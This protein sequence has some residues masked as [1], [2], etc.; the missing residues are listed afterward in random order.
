M[1]T[2]Q[3]NRDCLSKRFVRYQCI[4]KSLPQFLIQYDA[5]ANVKLALLDTEGALNSDIKLKKTYSAI[6]EK[7]KT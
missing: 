6:K 1:R 4:D 2:D 3:I 5:M 7:K